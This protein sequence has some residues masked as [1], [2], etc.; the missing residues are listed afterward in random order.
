MKFANMLKLV[1]E[2]RRHALFKSRQLKDT[3]TS[4]MDKMTRLYFHESVQNFL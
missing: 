4:L 3:H 2:N 1:F